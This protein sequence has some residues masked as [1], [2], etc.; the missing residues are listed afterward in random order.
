MHARRTRQSNGSDRRT[1]IRSPRFRSLMLGSE[2]S[3]TPPVQ[4]RLR[5]SL[6]FSTF[7]YPITFFVTA[8]IPCQIPIRELQ[9]KPNKLL[10]VRRPDAAFPNRRPASVAPLANVAVPPW[11]PQTTRDR[12]SFTIFLIRRSGPLCLRRAAKTQLLSLF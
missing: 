7:L 3:L 10:G 12:I 11:P 2:L 6:P 5:K 1:G 9:P 4:G 8:F